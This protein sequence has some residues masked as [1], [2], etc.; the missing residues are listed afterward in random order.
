MEEEALEEPK[1]KPENEDEVVVDVE[2]LELPNAFDEKGLENAE[3]VVGL[4]AGFSSSS[5]SPSGRQEE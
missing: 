5:S 2:A 4:A 1:L 3:V